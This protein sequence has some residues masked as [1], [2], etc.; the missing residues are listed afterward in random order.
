[1]YTRKKKIIKQYFFDYLNVSI[2]ND[3][4]ESTVNNLE[5][6]QDYLNLKRI[7]QM[8]TSEAKFR[9]VTPLV[10]RTVHRTCVNQWN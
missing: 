7:V 5:K 2:F 1:V 6:F 4:E 8:L 9:P 10:K 3:F